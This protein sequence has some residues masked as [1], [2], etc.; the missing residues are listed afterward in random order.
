MT[1]KTIIY[2]D[3]DHSGLDLDNKTF[4]QEEWAI[5]SGKIK[6]S[7]REIKENIEIKQRTINAYMKSFF[8]GVM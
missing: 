3:I 1:N 7:R 6:L 4:D 8:A 5:K 2:C